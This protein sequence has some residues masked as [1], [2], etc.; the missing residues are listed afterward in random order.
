M[1]VP[2]GSEIAATAEVADEVGQVKQLVD[3]VKENQLL[4]A[5]VLFI[6]WQADV[7][8]SAANYAQGGLC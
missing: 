2:S 5:L 4:T 8:I 7:F 6:L 1:S 3:L